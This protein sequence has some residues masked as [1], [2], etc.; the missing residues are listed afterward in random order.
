MDVKDKI[1]CSYISEFSELFKTKCLYYKLIA[2]QNKTEISFYFNI[3]SLLQLD[4]I[5]SEIKKNELFISESV[6]NGCLCFTFKVK[7]KHTY[8][9]R[10]LVKLLSLDLRLKRIC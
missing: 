3:Q 6:R 9:L 4:N 10:Y 1:I 5:R 8:T 2:L 7:D